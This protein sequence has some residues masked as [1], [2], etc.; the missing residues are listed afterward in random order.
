[1]ASEVFTPESNDRDIAERADWTHAQV[2]DELER[3][4]SEAGPM[5]AGSD[6]MWDGVA[7]GEWVHA[8]DVREALGEREAYGE[9]GLP[10]ALALLARVTREWGDHVPLEADLDD[11]DEPL[12]LGAS[13][14]ERPPARF[15]GD[16]PTLVRLYTGRPVDGEVYEL[17]GV[18]AKDLNIFG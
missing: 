10:D 11:L 7:F 15:T 16:G 18:E 12:R 13:G 3:G 14:S 6:G 1:L 17:T 9:S 8:G 4:M 2:L 5:L